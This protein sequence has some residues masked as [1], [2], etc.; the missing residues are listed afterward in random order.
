MKGSVL[1]GNEVLQPLMQVFVIEVGDL[2]PARYTRGYLGTKEFLLDMKLYSNGNNSVI[3]FLISEICD[4][5]IRQ[6]SPLLSYFSHEC[7]Q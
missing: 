4:V 2:N 7:L 5:A 3:A 1:G 6:Y